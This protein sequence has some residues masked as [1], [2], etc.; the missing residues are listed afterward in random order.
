MSCS[1]TLLKR[2]LALVLIVFLS[3]PFLATAQQGMRVGSNAAPSEM[4]HVEGAILLG[5]TSNTNAGTIRW[6][7]T[8]F[9]GYD[10]ATW[11]NLGSQGYPAGNN[12]VAFRTSDRRQELRDNGT[13]SSVGDHSHAVD[14]TSFNS[15]NSG[16]VAG[17]NAPYIQ[18]LMCQK[19]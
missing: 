5:T 12:H 6:N 9:Q 8:D 16:S 2:N 10:G 19:D 17:T 18:L 1:F 3:L 13:I 14:I 15:A 7:G 11:V 4:L